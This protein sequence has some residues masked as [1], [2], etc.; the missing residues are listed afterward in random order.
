MTPVSAKPRILHVITGLS[1]GGA[2]MMLFKLLSKTHKSHV[3]TVVS[4]KD[5]GTIGP[6]IK[7]LGVPVHTLNLGSTV[8]NPFCFFPMK[9]VVH[10]FRPDV[11]QGWMYHGNV[12]ASLASKFSDSHPPVLW[13]IQQ[14]VRRV[15]DYGW[16]TGLVIRFGAFISRDPAKI[17]YVSHTGAGQHASLGYLGEKKI[18]IPNGIDC[19]TFHPDDEA[20]R[21]A[22]A[23][24]GMGE[25]NVLVGLVARYHPMKDHAGFLAAAG[26]LARTHPRV[27]FVLIGKGVTNDQPAIQ[28]LVGKH[29]LQNR[30]LLLGERHD[31]PQLTA[32][33]DIACSASAW[34]EALSVAIGEAMACGV[35]CVVTDVGDSSY[36]VGDTGISVPP[37]EPQALAEA[38]GKLVDAGP[39]YRHT[40][41]DA[42]R[43]RVENDFSL[44]AI[45]RRYEEVYEQYALRGSN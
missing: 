38:L 21:Q 39:D 8:P 12:M 23:E 41:G 31:T 44:P 14:S 30:I 7:A 19:E 24:L 9:S 22:R 15:S 35:P 5:E 1:T 10:Q 29:D 43:K 18:V 42:A 45:V 33:L 40:L 17:I 28:Q 36:L 37:R 6:R 27:R 11:I 26:Q 16:L 20:R 3:Q 4:M 2:E 34:G 32:A 25:D 13:N